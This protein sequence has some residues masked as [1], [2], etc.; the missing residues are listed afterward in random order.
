MDE[1]APQLLSRAAQL[2]WV[3]SV[4]ILVDMFC[5]FVVFLVKA[6]DFKK[7][8]LA[9]GEKQVE[10]AYLQ[11]INS[12]P[13]ANETLALDPNSDYYNCGRVYQDQTTWT[14]AALAAMIMVYVHWALV[15]GSWERW[16]LVQAPRI[17]HRNHGYPPAPGFSGST[18]PGRN[19][20]PPSQGFGAMTEQ[21][22]MDE[23]A[24]R[25][26]DT[27]AT[28]LPSPDM[29]YPPE[30]HDPQ[31]QQQ[32]QEG[33]F[34]QPPLHGM[35]EEYRMPAQGYDGYH[36]GYPGMDN[37]GHDFYPPTMGN[38]YTMPAAEDYG[39]DPASAYYQQQLAGQ[40]LDSQPE[41][42]YYQQDHRGHGPPHP[43]NNDYY[44]Y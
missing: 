19:E 22:Y 40:G 36:G 4:L 26:D 34:Y 7:W 24:A 18:G 32:P 20:E 41:Q 39:V 3:C 23:Q 6:S 29:T 5:N 44:H 30:M 25:Q 8:C 28:A 43:S 13:T 21:A 17:I 15:I 9:N 38:E 33:D 14:L 42:L 10:L 2:I 1:A 12:Q 37:A 27:R 16:Y 35:D 31:Q 11:S